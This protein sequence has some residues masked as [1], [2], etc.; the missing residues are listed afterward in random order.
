M[1]V[2]AAFVNGMYQLT[3]NSGVPNNVIVMA[4]G[5][6]DELFSNLGFGDVKEIALR[7]EVVKDDDGERLASWEVYVVVNQPIP[8]R[9]CPVCGKM[10][11]V[12][13][14][15]ERLLEHSVPRK[16]NEVCAGSGTRVVGTRGRRFIQ[17]RG[18]EDPV[19][20]GKVH[21]LALAE[22]GVW[23]SQAG[24]QALPD[25]SKGEQAIQAVIGEGLARELGPDQ[26]K[27]TLEVGDYFD[28]G[29]RKWI[30]VG[31]LKSSG[32]MFDSEIWAK[33]GIEPLDFMIPTT[34][35][36]RG[37]RSKMSPTSSVFA[38]VAASSPR[39]PLADHR[40]DR[41]FTLVEPGNGC[42]PAE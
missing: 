15:G 4:D 16:E 35:H 23:F 32:S 39:Q 40:L 41:L 37:P 18:V 36:L 25:A 1:T 34:I 38:L 28:L 8:T 31:I 22:G 6:T 21:N 17:V 30:V 42:T 12:D 11:R 20:S 29:P 9:K 10:A 24:V 27:K 33:F 19:R 14:L 13:D 5:S 26:E 2:M 3:Q 7:D